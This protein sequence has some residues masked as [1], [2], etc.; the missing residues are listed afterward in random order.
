MNN[1]FYFETIDLF[2]YFGKLFVTGVIVA[3]L[4]LESISCIVFDRSGRCS[5]VSSLGE[6]SLELASEFELELIVDSLI[7]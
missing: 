2:F 7:D 3:E 1:N 5:L 4:D 6:L